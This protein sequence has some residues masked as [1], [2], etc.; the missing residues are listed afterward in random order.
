MRDPIRNKSHGFVLEQIEGLR[1]SAAAGNIKVLDVGCGLGDL[2]FQ[3]AERG[4]DVLG[5]DI[6]SPT[7]EEAKRLN[8]VDNLSFECRDAQRLGVEDKFDVVVLAEVLEHLG[9]PSGLMRDVKS[10]LDPRGILIV[11][12]PNGY[13]PRELINRFYQGCI[14]LKNSKNL[15]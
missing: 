12:V 10:L 15:V 1:G 9:D 14:L 4:Y 8:S 11:T 7:I 2:S 5:V 6:H 13:G 3:I